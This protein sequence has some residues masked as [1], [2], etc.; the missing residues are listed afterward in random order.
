MVS[1]RPA[2]VPPVP[3]GQRVG[4]GLAAVVL[5]VALGAA[6]TVMILQEHVLLVVAGV[7]L[8]A[9]DL[10]AVGY[11]VRFLL[12]PR[13]APRILERGATT[14]L[15]ESGVARFTAWGTLAASLAF[16]AVFVLAVG[17]PGGSGAGPGAGVWAA[18]LVLLLGVPT[19]VGVLHRRVRPGELVLG[20]DAVTLATWNADRTLAWDDIAE[21]TMVSTPRR[22]LVVYARDG[23]AIARGRAPA[24]LGEQQAR[25][26]GDAHRALAISFPHLTGD[27]AVLAAALEHWRTTPPARAELGTP[28]AR[29]RLAGGSGAA[30]TDR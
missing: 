3:A 10:L 25:S 6:A 26:V 1:G 11:L 30:G 7:L 17:V 8:L 9:A 24:G 21:V 2:V 4:L 18:V 5:G 16:L 29:A 28:A 13:G 12:T 22:T 23:D 15:P 19:V 20:P 27:P 14:V